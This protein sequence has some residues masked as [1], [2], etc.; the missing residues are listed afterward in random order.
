MLDLKSVTLWSCV[1]SPSEELIDRTFR[2]MRY[3]TRIAKFGEVVF[4]CCID[5]RIDN[6]C[7]WTV[8]RIPQLDMKRWNLFINREIPNH[9][10]G[11]FALSVHED[12]FILDPQLWSSD[13]LGSDY[14]GA[15]WPSGVVGNQGFCIESRK[16]LQEKMLLPRLPKDSSIPS[17]NFLC[18]THRN[19][20]ERTGI[21]FAPT[22]L[23]EK[24]STE[25][26]GDDRPSFGF[27]GRSHSRLKYS[28]GWQMIE[29][30]EAESGFYE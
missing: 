18:I 6:D 5:P 7:G 22:H 10:K 28:K 2:V 14:I 26:Y 11:D 9:I 15:P 8:I 30:M 19:R 29:R 4:F 24:F 20:L 17:D 25:M 13:F 23:A 16:M 3:C 27:H 12:G 21:R 1:W